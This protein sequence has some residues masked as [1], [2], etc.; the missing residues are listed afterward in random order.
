MLSEVLS[1]AV[2]AAASGLISWFIAKTAARS[3]IRKLRETW[4]HEKETAI[5]AEFDQMVSCVSAFL[6]HKTNPNAINAARAI[7]VYRAKAAVDLAPAVDSLAGLFERPEQNQ[8][9]IRE[10]LDTIIEL[11]RPENRQKDAGKN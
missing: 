6:M 4:A 10:A 8:Y 2:S 3:E 9:R 5:D 11:K 7:T 1:G